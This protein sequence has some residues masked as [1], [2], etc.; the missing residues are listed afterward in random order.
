MLLGLRGE[1]VPYIPTSFPARKYSAGKR[2]GANY[3]RA[4]MTARPW[5]CRCEGGSATFV[6]CQACPFRRWR[7]GNPRQELLEKISAK[8]AVIRW[9]TGIFA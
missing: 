1:S 7:E 5:G 6:R 9:S 4:V 8:N 3:G 2:G